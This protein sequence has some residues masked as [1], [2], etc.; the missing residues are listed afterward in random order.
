MYVPHTGKLHDWQLQQILDVHPKSHPANIDVLGD[1]PDT[2]AVRLGGS[3][4]V[5]FFHRE[6]CANASRQQALELLRGHPS[7]IAGVASRSSIRARFHTELSR[8]SHCKT[9]GLSP[10]PPSRYKSPVREITR[11]GRSHLFELHH[12][13]ILIIPTYEHEHRAICVVP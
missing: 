12:N 2:F 5:C 9:F 11:N 1:G 7:G 4:S 6:R 3:G 10:P 8:S 13:G